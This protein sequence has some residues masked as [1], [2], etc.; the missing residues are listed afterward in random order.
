MISSS[1]RAE[2]LIARAAAWIWAVNMYTPDERQV[3]RGLGRLL[4]Q[5]HDASELS[6]PVCPCAVGELGDAVVL[7][8]RARA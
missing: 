4:D 7:R 1:P 2:G 5:A 3:G 8:V 6:L